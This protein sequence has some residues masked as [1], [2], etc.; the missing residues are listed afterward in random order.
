MASIGGLSFT[1]PLAN[2]APAP[3]K[4]PAFIPYRP[5]TYKSPVNMGRNVGLDFAQAAVDKIKSLD[6]KRT[7]TVSTKKGNTSQKTTSSGSK[8]K[9][10]AT[11]SGPTA[12]QRA[13][14][15]AAAAQAAALAKAKADYSALKNNTFSS[16]TD[17][18]KGTGNQ[19][20]S[21]LLDWQDEYKQ[22]QNAINTEATNNELTKVQGTRDVLDMVG[23]GIRSGGV[24]LNN[25][26]AANSSAAQAMADA[27]GKIG[28]KQQAQVNNGYELTNNSIGQE[29]SDLALAQ[30]QQIRHAGES[31]DQSVNSIV[32][33]AADKLGAL[34]Q[35]AAYASLPDRIDVESQKAAIRNQALAELQQYDMLLSQAVSNNPVSSRNDNYSSA[36]KLANAGN[37]TSAM[38]NLTSAVPSQL[39][40][41][42][43]F[44]SSLPIFTYGG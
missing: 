7:P 21:G 4:A 25:N 17:L 31:K 15:S 39:Q 34:N 28:Q 33:T 13:A 6:A 2:K 40:G 10:V 16:I 32:Q 27:Y 38:H 9:T 18:V 22:K 11:N 14:S 41:T 44:A 19:Y 42:G 24:T 37:D 30:A 36:L 43:P 12:A 20:K 23:N 8:T 29:Q 26:N 3:K 5:T 35:S 1:N